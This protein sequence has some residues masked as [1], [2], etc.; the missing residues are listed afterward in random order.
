MV[1][2]LLQS[3]PETGFSWF[4]F[5]ALVGALILG[6]LAVFF[7][8]LLAQKKRKRKRRHPGHDRIKPTLAEIRGL[9][10]VRTHDEKIPAENS[11]R[12]L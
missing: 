4:N 11:A 6:V 2:I 8:I 1:A 5:L 7:W 12:D 10:P 3:L 9:P